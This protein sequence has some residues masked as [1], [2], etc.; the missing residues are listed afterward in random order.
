MKI[1]RVFL[2]LNSDAL[3]KT[4]RR[5]RRYLKNIQLRSHGNDE[6]F[7]SKSHMP[8]IYQKWYYSINCLLLY[9]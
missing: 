6:V 1:A 7:P 5:F 3:V 4:P 2:G 8:K 9:P